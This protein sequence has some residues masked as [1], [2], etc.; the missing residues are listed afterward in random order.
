MVYFRY[1]IANTLHKGGNKD[2]DNT[3]VHKFFTNAG[4]TSTFKAPVAY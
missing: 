4:A 1:I 3:G 2:D